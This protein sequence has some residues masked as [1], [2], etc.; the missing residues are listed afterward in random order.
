MAVIKKHS[1]KKRSVNY[2]IISTKSFQPYQIQ[3]N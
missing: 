1:A 2:L 3:P